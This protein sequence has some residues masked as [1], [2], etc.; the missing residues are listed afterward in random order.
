MAGGSRPSQ[1]RQSRSDCEPCRLLPRPADRGSGDRERNTGLHHSGAPFPPVP[2]PKATSPCFSAVFR[3]FF[4][5]IS[6]VF[7]TVFPL[8][9][10]MW[11]YCG[12]GYRQLWSVTAAESAAGGTSLIIKSCPP[13]TIGRYVTIQQDDNSYLTLCEVV[14]FG[15][16]SALNPLRFDGFQG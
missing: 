15:A 12:A 14:V 13:S 5:C 7:L 2:R 6:T 16:I 11:V 8:F 10:L 1:G 9:R 3:L 4:D